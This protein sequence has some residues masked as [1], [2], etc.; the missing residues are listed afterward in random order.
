M[1]AMVYVAL[2]LL[3]IGV[4]LFSR[5]PF[6]DNEPYPA[7]LYPSFAVAKNPDGEFRM[8]VQ[9]ILLLHA[10][11]DTTEVDKGLLFDPKPFNSSLKPIIDR[12]IANVQEAQRNNGP[13]YQEFQR[14]LA[15]RLANGHD[16]EGVQAVAIVSHYIP[17]WDNGNV[18]G[19]LTLMDQV[20][21]TLP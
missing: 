19:E 15:G 17:Y 8:P 1:F 21:V 10:N 3:T 12:M 16:L 9:S 2:L 4:R 7:F 5:M 18:V 14:W 6:P 11:G 13:A 20:L